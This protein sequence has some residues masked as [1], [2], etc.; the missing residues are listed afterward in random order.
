VTRPR[1]EQVS[2][3]DTPY[4]HVVSRC[5]RRTYLCGYDSKTGKNYEHRRQWIENRIRLLSSI[6]AIDIC[7]YAVMSNHLHIVVKITPEEL[8]TLTDFEI[9]KRWACL[10]KGSILFQ[11]WLEGKNLD[12]AELHTV[13][14]SVEVYRNRLQDLG[15]FMKC[16]NEP[17]ARQANKEDGCTGHFWQSRYKS[18]A[19]LTE[20]ALLTCMAYVDLNP[21]RAKMSETPETS[22]HTSIKERLQPSFNLADAVAEQIGLEALLQFDLTPK[23][24]LPFEIGLFMDEQKGLLFS[25]E[26]YLTLVDTTGRYIRDNKR[27]AI[28]ADLLPILERVNIDKQIWLSNVTNFEKHY[29]SKFSKR[30]QNFKRTA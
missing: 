21:V 28:S 8:D 29:Q 24:L 18:Q 22:N 4:Y 6:F 1:K 26:D 23:P 2:L 7:A 13:L 3:D 27:G 20:E 12:Q 17:I 19:L 11:K 25:F 14:E 30:V 10:Y 15:W 5:V 16:L 9:A